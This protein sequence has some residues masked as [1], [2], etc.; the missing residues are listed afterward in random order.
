[1][2]FLCLAYGDGKEW[3]RLSPAEQK[4]LL[5]QDDV[6]RARG[7]IVVA[8]KGPVTTL[9]AWDGSPH[10]THEAF[11]RSDVPLAGCGIIE[12]ADL[13]EAIRLVKDTPCARAHGAVELH[14]IHAIN[15]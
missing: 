7:D 12:A 4:T 11:A 14:P 2:K 5:A 8:V 9:Q 10:T 15:L 6:L 3:E 13:D 1:M